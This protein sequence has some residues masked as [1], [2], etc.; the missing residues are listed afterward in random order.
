MDIFSGFTCTPED[1]EMISPGLIR[2]LGIDPKDMYS[3]V[4]TIVRI[5]EA[6]GKSKGADAALLPFCHT[7]EASAL[8]ADIKP[9]DDTAGPRPASYTA[10]DLDDVLS[11]LH[12][13]A[14]SHPDASRL[15][16]ACRVLAARMPVGFQLSGPI[17][18]LS[19]MMDLSKVFK[20]WR[21][22]PDKITEVLDGLR[23]LL[24]GLAH[25]MIEAGVSFIS[26][27]DPAASRDILGPKFGSA[28]STVFT[29]KFLRDL[30][31]E[32]GSKAALCVCP[33]TVALLGSCGLAELTTSSGDF[34]GICVKRA[35]SADF[36][37]N[38]RL[39]A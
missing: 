2:S 5:A 16:D 23:S 39:T 8:G 37:K 28:L 24:I 30:A 27:S 21:K 6:G 3:S 14:S 35:G 13:R 29:H 17:S 20:T 10:S 33:L 36:P 18:I 22:K 31:D 7:I 11:R 12:V 25:D 9:A 4:D 19:C 15:I 32:C 26:Y 38:I 34:T 1:T